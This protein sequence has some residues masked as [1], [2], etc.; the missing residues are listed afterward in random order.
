MSVEYT[1]IPRKDTSYLKQLGE[2]DRESH[3]LVKIDKKRIADRIEREIDG[4]VQFKRNF[5]VIAKKEDIS[6]QEA[7]DKY[8]NIEFT[9]EQ[10]PIQV[11]IF[12]TFVSVDIGDVS[13]SWETLLQVFQ[14]LEDEGLY[15]WDSVGGEFIELSSF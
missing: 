13:G 11:D 12:D 6:I 3:N 7:Q 9:Y 5:E 4:M 1:A 8:D 2:L 10:G 15:I 14:I